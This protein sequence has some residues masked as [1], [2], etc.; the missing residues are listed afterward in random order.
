MGEGKVARNTA[1]LLA[2]SVGQKLLALVYFMVVARLAG[3]EGTGQY[4]IATTFALVFSS[5]ADLGMSNVVVREVAR[6]PEKAASHLGAAISIKSLL[7]VIVAVV[8]QVV[9]WLMGYSDDV[10]MMIAVATLAVLI[11][12]V[13]VTFYAVLR[14]F[15]NLRPEAIGVIIGQ[16]ILVTVGT[17]SYFVWRTPLVMVT[18]L[19]CTTIW[20]FIWSALALGRHLNLRPR[21]SWNKTDLRFVWLT[22]LPFALAAVFSRI[23]SYVDSLMLSKLGTEAQVGLYGAANKLTFAFI[24]LPSVFAAALYPAM[25]EYYVK[26]RARLARLFVDSCRYLMVV[27]M[28]IVFG[29]AVLSSEIITMIFGDNFAESAESLLVLIF[30]L[31]FAFLYWPTG[32]LLNASNRQ[33][34]NTAAM[35]ITMA[36]NIALNF[37]M[38]PKYGAMGAAASALATNI[39]LFVM[40]LA[41]AHPVVNID[42][43]RLLRGAGVT[44]FAATFMAVNIMLARP[45]LPWPVLIPMGALVYVGVLLGMGGLSMAEAKQLLGLLRRRPDA[46]AGASMQQ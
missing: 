42:Y 15:Q 28:P 7:I 21:F 24:F 45:Y 35:G 23:Y 40:A 9:A 14:G 32:S 44:L 11:D 3:V 2:A 5:F 17:I 33:S 39:L 37:F 30:A 8:S 31:I 6:A 29:I 18:A 27:V 16:V 10:R 26:D 41:F 20:N 36:V 22:T 1:Y 34:Y 43:S 13:S 4:V 12:S 19:L 25:S 38:L 46:S